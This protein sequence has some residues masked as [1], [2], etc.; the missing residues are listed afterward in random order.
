[1]EK[2]EYFVGNDGR[3]YWGGCLSAILYPLETIGERSMFNVTLEAE[4]YGS[5][6]ISKDAVYETNL[7]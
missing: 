3:I 5:V 7:N 2:S 4:V 1:M 6:I